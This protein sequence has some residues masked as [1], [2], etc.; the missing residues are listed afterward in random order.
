MKY[1]IQLTKTERKT[2]TVFADNRDQALTR[3]MEGHSDFRHSDVLVELHED[4]DKNVEHE[5]VGVCENCERNIWEGDQHIMTQDD[6]MLCGTCGDA[7][8]ET[9]PSAPSDQ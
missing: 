2:V 5:L 8:N 3:A 7:F 9:Q 1:E 6:C 4:E